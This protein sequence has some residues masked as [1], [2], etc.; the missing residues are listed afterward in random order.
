MTMQEIED[1]PTISPEVR[2]QVKQKRRLEDLIKKM[3]IAL[4]QKEVRDKIT[5]RE[6]T[7]ES[8]RYVAQ[9]LNNSHKRVGSG[10]S[11][12]GKGMNDE[13]LAQRGQSIAW[14]FKNA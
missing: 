8:S 13:A 5:P 1:D 4:K 10:A 14:M 7:N 6:A 3:E 12:N 11:K 9:H 2:R